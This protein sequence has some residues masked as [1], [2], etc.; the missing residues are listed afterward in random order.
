MLGGG[1]VMLECD[2]LD[3]EVALDGVPMGLCSDY[4]TAEHGLPMGTGMHRLDFKHAGRSP[5]QTEIEPDRA[6]AVVHASLPTLSSEGKST[7]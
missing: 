5:Y 3:A 2:P 7:P 4:A 1:Q 6:G